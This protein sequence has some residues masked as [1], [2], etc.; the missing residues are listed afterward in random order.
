[1]HLEEED[2]P[3]TSSTR[4]DSP[5]HSEERRFS[6]PSIFSNPDMFSVNG[7][8]NAGA[9]D[10]GQGNISRMSENSAVVTDRSVLDDWVDVDEDL[11]RGNR[12]L[13]LG[14]QASSELEANGGD[15][16]EIL[17]ETDRPLHDQQSQHQQSLQPRLTPAGI[18][19]HRGRTVSAVTSAGESSMYYTTAADSRNASTVAL[20][21]GDV[22]GDRSMI[23]QHQPSF[24][25][26]RTHITANSAA[27]TVMGDTPGF[28]RQQ[29]NFRPAYTNDTAASSMRE[30][31]FYTADA[32]T[33]GGLDF[34][35]QDP[36]AAIRRTELSPIFVPR[37]AA[38]DRFEHAVGAQAVLADLAKQQQQQQASTASASTP[39]GVQSSRGSF[40]DF[41]VPEARQLAARRNSVSQHSFID[42]DSED[43]DGQPAVGTDQDHTLRARSNVERTSVV[44]A[45]R[46]DS[47]ISPALGAV[48]PSVFVEQPADTGA[49]T[50]TGVQGSSLST[51]PITPFSPAS[52][53]SQNTA[54]TEAADDLGGTRISEVLES[55]RRMNPEEGQRQSFASSPLGGIRGDFALGVPPS[56]HTGTASRDRSSGLSHVRSASNTSLLSRLGDFPDPPNASA[57]SV[58]LE[59]SAGDG[60]A[61][62]SPITLLRPAESDHTLA[63]RRRAA[64]SAQLPAGSGNP[65]RSTLGTQTTSIYTFSSSNEKVGRPSA[66]GADANADVVADADADAGDATLKH[67]RT[68]SADGRPQR[69]SFLDTTT[70]PTRP[71][72]GALSPQSHIAFSTGPNSPAVPSAS[73]STPSFRLSGLFSRRPKHERTYSDPSSL[74]RSS[75]SGAGLSHVRRDSGGFESAEER[76]QSWRS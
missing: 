36:M 73:P 30:A 9:E 74:G 76:R 23:L 49:P 70:S 42:D 39:S 37:P 64:E 17:P 46:P 20:G 44:Q 69:D 29:F 55:Y 5:A 31:P 34:E 72:S 71:R 10:V 50:A 45:F 63:S 6:T 25:S 3:T 21:L 54:V 15:Q 67:A 18:M 19:D 12:R 40:I 65:S 8:N 43:E 24:V 59:G 62:E 26:A 28:E 41:D 60:R 51:A 7:A 48:S 11:L 66:N 22:S 68:P 75:G 52:H 16:E 53:Y 13:W 32:D 35:P 33:A 47:G 2:N 38:T 27:P 1:M 14:S 56:P 61:E 4:P 57:S 58:N